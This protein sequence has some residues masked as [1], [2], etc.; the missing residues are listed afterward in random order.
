[1]KPIWLVTGT[2][3]GM[4]VEMVNPNHQFELVQLK[5]AIFSA[6]CVVEGAKEK[7]G[8]FTYFLF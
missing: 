3:Q 4:G 5:H 1:M 8:F 7:V 6:S 2:T